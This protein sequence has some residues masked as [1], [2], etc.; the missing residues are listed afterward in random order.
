MSVPEFCHFSAD[1]IR[2]NLRVMKH[3]EIVYVIT[4]NDTEE[5][6]IE[7]TLDGR[8][9]GNLWCERCGERLQ[10]CDL[11]ID[12]KQRRRG[13]GTALLQ[14]AINAADAAGVREIWGEV[15]SKDIEGWPGLLRWY[16]KHGFAVQEPDDECIRTA[17]RKIVRRQ[18]E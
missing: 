1:D 2:R 15:T 11:R 14:R 3:G 18:Q 10:I 8:R 17:A 6:N 12:E 9:V 13:I 7:A 4:E 5:L 16:E